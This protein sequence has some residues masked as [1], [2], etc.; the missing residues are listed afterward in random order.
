MRLARSTHWLLWGLL[1]LILAAYL[2]HRLWLSEDQSL[3]LLGEVMHGHHQ[4]EL[5]CN[6]CHTEPF[7]GGEVIQNACVA[8][9]A[10]G[11][12]ASNDTHPASKFNDPRNADLLRVINAQQCVSCHTEHKPGR[13]AAMGVTLPMDYCI[14]C[15][16]DIEQSRPSHE[17]MTFLSCTNSGCH[18]YHDNR[19]LYEDFLIQHAEAPNVLAEP[20]RVLLQPGKKNAERSALS[21]ADADMPVDL[22]ADP[23]IGDQWWHSAHARAAVNCTDCHASDATDT[24]RTA[25]L[26]YQVCDA[27]HADEVA[28]F[29]K[30]LHGMRLAV[31]LSPMRPELARRPMHAD[32]HGRELGCMSCHSDH[33]FDTRSAAVDACL[34]CHADDHS[35][36][37]VGSPHHALWEREL[38]GAGVPGSGVSCATCHLP[39]EV[40]RISGED[41]VLVQ[42]N[43]NHNLRPVEKMARSVC[44]SCHGLPFTLDA[45]ADPELRANNFRGSPSETIPSVDMAVTRQQEIAEERARRRAD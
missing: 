32:A 17:G 43:Q 25:P 33:R 7:G 11:L 2:S 39:R 37:Y 13:T 34:G 45:L 23:S 15:H 22:D 3:F 19:A 12:G 29:L 18:N 28:G 38:S 8:C 9:H 35:L 26:D 10:D 4:I 21:L 36:A 6:A 16:Q 42:H 24:W 40:H 5:A 30:G 27:C 41:R 14:H 1:T 20:W 31:E 44:L